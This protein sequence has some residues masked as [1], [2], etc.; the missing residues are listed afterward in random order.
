[1]GKDLGTTRLQ[2]IRRVQH[3]AHRAEQD[4]GMWKK[5]GIFWDVMLH[6]S[7]KNRR[8]GGTYRL[9]HQGDKNR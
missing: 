9:L 3:A 8:F 5:N 7:C 4:V 6:G 2:T 1:V